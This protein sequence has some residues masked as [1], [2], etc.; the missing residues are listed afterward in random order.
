MTTTR[1]T[2]RAAGTTD[3]IT[4]CDHCGRV[5]LMGTVR[6]VAG[7]VEVFMGSSCA[8]SMTG[9]PV[10]EIDREARAGDTAARK[11]AAAAKEA[12]HRALMAV[13]DEWFAANG[14]VRDFRSL[15]AWRAA[16]PS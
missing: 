14:L 15:K 16:H 11:A 6:M 8:A 9:R 1:T 7:E 12:E 10:R 4:T 13:Q 5:D 3:E 2:Y